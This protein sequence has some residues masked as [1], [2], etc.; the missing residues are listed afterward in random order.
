MPASIPSLRLDLSCLSIGELDEG[1]SYVI[2]VFCCISNCVL[3]LEIVRTV[4]NDE[5]AI[6]VWIY[7]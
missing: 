6:C 4:R 7:E 5:C 3:F 1:E 2:S